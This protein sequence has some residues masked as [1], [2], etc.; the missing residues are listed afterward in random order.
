MTIPRVHG[1]VSVSATARELT[2]RCRSVREAALRDTA[3]RLSVVYI[4]AAGFADLLA[5]VA[6][7]DVVY[8][9]PTP[10]TGGQWSALERRGAEVRVVS[11]RKRPTGYVPIR[12]GAR[13]R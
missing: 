11:D 7:G 10:G 6:S 3:D 2:F 13:A 1:Y 9:S 8:V 12:R 4:G 5:A